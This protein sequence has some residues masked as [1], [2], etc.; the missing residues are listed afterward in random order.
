MVT[1]LLLLAVAIGAQ[2][3]L[4]VE[5]KQLAVG[6]TGVAR[7]TVLTRGLR[8][9]R[10]DTRPPEVSVPHGLEVGFD[11]QR[12][13][14]S[15]TNGTIVQVTQFVYRLTARQ[16]GD[17]T[18]GPV[19]VAFGNGQVRKTDAVEV[20]VVARGDAEQPEI[21]V[22]AGFDSEEAWEGEVVLYRFG[23][24]STVPGIDVEWEHPRF[25]GLRVPQQGGGNIQRYTVDD[26]DGMITV[27][28]GTIPLI[29]TGTGERDQGPGLAVVKI[30]TGAPRFGT[31]QRVRTQRWPTRPAALT[32]RPL[33]EAPDGFSGLVGDFEVRSE[34]SPTEA[35]VG[36]SLAWSLVIE[37]A[38]ALEGYAAPPY[39]A[40][41]VTLYE[42]NSAIDAVI[43]D[44]GDYVA[45]ASFDRVLVPTGEGTLELPSFELITFSP[46][47]GRYVTHRV[48]LPDVAVRPGREGGGQITSFAEGLGELAGP[49]AEDEPAGA[50]PRA[51]LTQGAATTMPASAWLPFLLLLAAAP[52]VGLFGRDAVHEVRRRVDDWRSARIPTGPTVDA[53]V[54]QLPTDPSQRLS[55]LDAALRLVQRE[56][57]AHDPIS[58]LF[59]LIL[60]R[61]C[62]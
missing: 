27:S 13:Q 18:I 4:S 23:F 50:A 11:G 38:G 34:L 26:P 36:Q 45:R 58:A 62:S 55:R 42:S 60:G 24:R 3:D 28:K 57:G 35:V 17:W 33:P 30:P 31:F 61:F 32:V 41:G 43:D 16:E 46:A 15:N 40:P 6:Q 25:D 2:V 12:Q 8:D 20:K 7:V 22:E 52:G 51:V 59:S 19:D 9:A 56:A 21:V 49:A 29:A 10:P 5:P 48:E 37:G 39:E 53:M 1:W 14:F 54:Q 47:K 44:D